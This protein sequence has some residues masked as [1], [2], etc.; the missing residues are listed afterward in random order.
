MGGGLSTWSVDSTDYEYYGGFRDWF[1]SLAIHASHWDLSVSPV[2]HYRQHTVVDGEANV[3]LWHHGS[4]GHSNMSAK[5]GKKIF[6]DE[7]P[8]QVLSDLYRAGADKIYL[9]L[10]FCCADWATAEKWA[11]ALASSEM[12]GDIVLVKSESNEVRGCRFVEVVI[13]MLLE[14]ADSLYAGAFEYNERVAYSDRL[15]SVFHIEK[16][17]NR[18]AFLSRIDMITGE[19]IETLV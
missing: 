16:K 18:L 6:I 12:V 11:R 4:E 10:P 2:D 14:K 15:S 9:V 3:I 1:R 13:D 19:K 7:S 17:I 5:V 8:S